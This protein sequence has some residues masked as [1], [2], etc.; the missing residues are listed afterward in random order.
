MKFITTVFGYTFKYFKIKEINKG[1]WR[2]L[3]RISGMAE[4]YNAA[5]CN[6]SLNLTS[7]SGFAAGMEL[8]KCV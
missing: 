3:L 1:K 4:R 5:L 2:I 8:M 7:G 6:L